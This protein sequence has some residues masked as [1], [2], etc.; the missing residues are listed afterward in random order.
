MQTYKNEGGVYRE[1]DMSLE[2]IPLTLKVIRRRRLENEARYIVLID[3][4]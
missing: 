2:D 3:L 1:N 4:N